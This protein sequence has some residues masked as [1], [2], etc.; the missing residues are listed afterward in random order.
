MHFPLRNHKAMFRL[1]AQNSVFAYPDSFYKVWTAETKHDMQ[2]QCRSKLHLE[3]VLKCDSD[4]T[5][6]DVG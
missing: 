1:L 2:C 5:S 6:T 3:V 4:L